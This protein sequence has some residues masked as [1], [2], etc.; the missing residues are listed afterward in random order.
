MKYFLIITL[1][2]LFVTSCV[3]SKKLRILNGPTL[4]SAQNSYEEHD[5]VFE[6]NDLIEILLISEDQEASSLFK[7]KFEGNKAIVTYMSGVP[8]QGGFLID[9]EGTINLPY[10]GKIQAATKTRSELT[11]ELTEKLSEY[12]NNPIVQISL[13]NFK[14]TVLGEVKQTGTFNIPN[15]RVTILQAIATAGEFTNYSKRDEVHVIRES[16]G[17]KEEFIIDLT[18]KSV[19]NSKA[20]FLKQNDII[21]IPQLKSKSYSINNQLILPFVSFASLILTALNLILK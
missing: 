10:L 18:D 14:V 12:I 6:K 8:A 20:F 17:K 3:D 2:S 21:Y 4:D 5:I 19:F 1:L 11:K 13:L 7:T 15:E 16:N 9:K